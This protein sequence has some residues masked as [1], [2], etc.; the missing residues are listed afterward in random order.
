MRIRTST[1]RALFGLDSLISE[2]TLLG[3]TPIPPSSHPRP[4]HCR[5]PQSVGMGATWNVTLER[6]KGEVIGRELRSIAA[7]NRPNYGAVYGLS[8][9]S[10][11]INIIR[12]PFWVKEI[13]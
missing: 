13:N 5:F 11:M 3:G 4:A 10:P 6:A 1:I 9:F 8:C 7:A 12:D 2:L